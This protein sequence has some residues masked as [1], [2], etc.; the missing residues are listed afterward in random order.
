LLFP[1]SSGIRASDDRASVLFRDDAVADQDARFTCEEAAM[2][3]SAFIT[4]LLLAGSPA[5]AGQA[6]AVIQ[7]GITIT[8]PPQTSAKARA[9]RSI[10]QAAAV[11]PGTARAV[12]PK[13]PV[14][15]RL[16]RPQ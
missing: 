9:T 2:W 16:Q 10:Q 11:S 15:A 14:P 1:I 8:G 3:R 12:V 7:V 6:S 4:I 5:L 13:R